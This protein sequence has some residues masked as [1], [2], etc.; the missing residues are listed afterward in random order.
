MT[1]CAGDCAGA[2]CIKGCLVVV[3]R[4]DLIKEVSRGT[5]AFSSC[6]YRYTLSVSM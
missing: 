5:E 4:Q 6:H 3:S 2:V 1:V